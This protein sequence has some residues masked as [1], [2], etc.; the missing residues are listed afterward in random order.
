MK[1]PQSEYRHSALWSA[2][3]SII[4]DLVASGELTLS[5]APD[6]VTAQICEE[7]VARRMVSPE[8]LQDRARR[9]ERG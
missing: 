8:G 1:L 6:Y 7:L 2:V 9:G 5:T 4:K 3:D